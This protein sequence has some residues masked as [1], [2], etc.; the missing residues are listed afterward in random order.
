MHEGELLAVTFGGKLKGV[1]HH[2]FHTVGRVHRDLVGHLV[3]CSLPNR[4]A[5]ADV[6]TLGPLTNHHKVHLAGGSEWTGDARIQHG[7]AQIDVVVKLEPQLEQQP[8]LNVGSG[9]SRIP[10]DP[11]NC[12]EQNR[13]MGA[14]R[15]QIGIG[16]YVTG[17][18]IPGCTK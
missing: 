15:C 6:G 5:V 1:P 11:A 17:G 7:R 9:Q 14:N 12:S 3:R 18:Q 16:E 8:A 13:I 10:R 2:A 4:T